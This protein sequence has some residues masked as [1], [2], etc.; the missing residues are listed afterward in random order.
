M[1]CAVCGKDVCTH[2]RYR[3]NGKRWI[4]D[5]C[6]GSGEGVNPAHYF[7][8]M[9]DGE[10]VNPNTCEWAGFDACKECSDKSV[11]LTHSQRREK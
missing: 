3:T 8:P 6:G 7:V 4:C 10:V 2:W 5:M 9:C 11:A 1:N